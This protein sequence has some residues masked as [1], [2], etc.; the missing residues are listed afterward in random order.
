MQCD[1][2]PPPENLTN[3]KNN[4]FFRFLSLL[5]RFVGK[6]FKKI[7]GFALHNPLTTGIVALAA[8]VVIGGFFIVDSQFTASSRTTR[9]GLENI[10]ELATQ[11]GYFTNVQVL[12][13]AQTLWG[14]Q[15]PFTE[16]KSIFSYDGVIKAGVDFEKISYQ[17]DE[18]N[19]VVT[20]KIPEVKI[21]SV[22]VDENSIEIYD[23]RQSIF[24]PFT[25]EDFGKSRIAMEEEII[26]QAKTNGLMEQAQ[27]NAQMLLKG[28]LSAQFDPTVYEFKFEKI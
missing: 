25:V 12:S 18:K 13:D 7:I 3:K 10:G 20:V 23:E 17:A 8:V 16:S 4:P 24:T 22:Q 5:G 21:L 26:S 2:Y 9:F 11:A 19:H 15:V 28:F 6:A 27:N 1:V 14:W